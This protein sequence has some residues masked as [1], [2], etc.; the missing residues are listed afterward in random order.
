MRVLVVDDSMTMRRLVID[1]IRSFSN[2]EI[3]EAGSAEEARDAIAQGPEIGLVLLDLHL[4]GMSGIEFLCKM[5]QDTRTAHIPV[6]M[7]TSEREKAHVIAALRAGARNYIVKPFTQQLFRKKVGPLLDA[8]PEAAGQSTGRLVG[9]IG[10]TSP[11]EVIQLIAM[12][13]KTGV[14]EFKS[15]D[16]TFEIHF[17]HGQIEHA[18]GPDG[19]AGEDAVGGAAELT[20]GVFTFR[21]ETAD[22]PVTIRR[23]TEMIMLE[24]FSKPPR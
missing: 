4:P 16:R 19:L 11:L 17:K 6:V 2:A 8:P 12:T 24:A 9:S 23:S 21:T 22:H 1:A 15:G 18:T 5:R 7:V 20:D 3:V 13:K 14:L 10:Q